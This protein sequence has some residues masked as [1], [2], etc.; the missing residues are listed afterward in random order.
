MRHFPALLRHE[1]RSLAHAPSTYVAGVLFLLL[2]AAIYYLLLSQY[3]AEQFNV[4]PG[5]MFFQAFWL[6][7][8]FMVPLLTMRSLAE[9]RRMHTLETLLSA[10]V[11]T[12]EVIL[13]KFLA[14]WILYCLLWLGVMLFPVSS[15]F[16]ALAARMPDAHA[17]AVLLG[18]YAFVC[19]SGL[20]YIATGILSSTLT[21]SQLVAG[22]LCFGVLI[23]PASW[24][25][26]HRHAGTRPLVRMAEGAS[27]LLRQLRASRQLHPR[28]HRHAPLPVLPE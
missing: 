1:L 21:R 28:S 18:G 25:K 19:I 23:H 14:S 20:L 24:P 6:P 4:P 11:T 9:E 2:M 5:E 15:P 27:A 26:A 17:H 13:S 3:A 10:P 12:A 16:T 8:L 22:I 7:V